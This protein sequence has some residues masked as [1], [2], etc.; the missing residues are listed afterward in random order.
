MSEFLDELARGLAQP[1]P[2]RRVLRLIGAAV[3]AW[4]PAPSRPRRAQGPRST[5]ATGR[6][7]STGGS[8]VPRRRSTA[9]RPAAH[10]SGGA[11]SVPG[12]RRMGA[13]N[14]RPALARI[15]AARAC[16][17]AVAPTSTAAG[18]ERTRDSRRTASVA[19]RASSDVG[20]TDRDPGRTGRSA[21]RRGRNA[22]AARGRDTAVPRTR[23]E[24]DCRLDLGQPRAVRLAG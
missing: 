16:A 23:G 18:R 12:T 7:P 22:A 8:S 14:T 2:R 9:S 24:S 13:P 6:W 21:A 11:R 3:S 1:M 17:S 19:R 15:R 4:A 5:C 10:P 20:S